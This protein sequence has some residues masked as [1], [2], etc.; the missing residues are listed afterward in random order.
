MTTL[1][2]ASLTAS[3]EATAD[4]ARPSRALAARRWFLVAAPVLAGAF[5]VVGAYAD[6]AAGIMDDRLFKIYAEN[7]GP[8]QFKSLGFHWAYAFWI[9]P[10]LLVAGYVK[11]RGAWLANVAAFLGFVGMT[12]LPGLLF[13]DWY[14]SAIGQLYGVEGVTAVNDRMTE[15]M[16]GITAFTVPGMLGF[17]LALPLAA[18]ALWR[19]RLVR[20]WAPVSVLAGFAAFT[21]SN[22]MWWG[23][24]ITTVCF[25]VFSVALERATRPR[26][27]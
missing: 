7:P 6:P 22:V 16:W 14:D 20:W 9:A 17:V 26:L 4:P 23:C 19:A 13:L 3:A 2:A 21:L 11:G 12:T 8:L 1:D 15:T 10:A 25:A 27:G 24:A 18:C 5:A